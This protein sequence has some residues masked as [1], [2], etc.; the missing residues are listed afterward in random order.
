M[1]ETKW[2]QAF[3]LFAFCDIAVIAEQ[4]TLQLSAGNAVRILISQVGLH[5]AY[6]LHSGII[7][8]AYAVLDI[9]LL[10][11]IQL[12]QPLLQGGN[13]IAAVAQGQ[14]AVGLQFI[15]ENLAAVGGCA[16]IDKVQQFPKELMAPALKIIQYS[17]LPLKDFA[18]AIAEDLQ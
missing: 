10:Q 13:V 11:I 9:L 5:G 1:P 2:F 12:P 17:Q 16:A 18:D 8:R 3:S 15:V 14:A 4:V 7:D 6:T